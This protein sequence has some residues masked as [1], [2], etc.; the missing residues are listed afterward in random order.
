MIDID[1]VKD[2]LPMPELMARLGLGAH[3][4]SKTLCPFHEDSS[5]SFGIKKGKGARWFFKC[6]AGCEPQPY[7][8]E[9]D[10]IQKV[11]GI[12]D[13]GEALRQYA[14]LA[15]VAPNGVSIK[16]HVPRDA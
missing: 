9:I 10:L 16:S 4:K 13:K 14:D 7:G 5:P 15:G 11:L 3:A 8:D 2:A 6:Y 12:A 1:K